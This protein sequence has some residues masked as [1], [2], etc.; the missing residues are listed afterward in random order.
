[1][2]LIYMV[3][4][5]LMLLDVETESEN[6]IFLKYGRIGNPYIIQGTTVPCDYTHFLHYFYYS[7][8]C[9][10]P[11]FGFMC[12]NFDFDLTTNVRTSTAMV[13]MSATRVHTPTVRVRMSSTRVPELQYKRPH[14]R[15]TGPHVHYGV[16]M[17]T[18]NVRTPTVRVCT[19]ATQVHTST[20]NVCMVASLSKGHEVNYR[21]GCN[22]KLHLIR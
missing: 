1:M 21:P 17:S 3:I 20:K 15:Y 16:H 5:T 19:S 10:M 14:V 18:T 13:R 22:K 7:L 11:P 4:F 2:G 9:A 12:I 8:T 6:W